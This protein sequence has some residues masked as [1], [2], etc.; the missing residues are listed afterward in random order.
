MKQQ[1]AIVHTDAVQAAGKI[2]VDFQAL[3]VDLMS[4][5]SHKMYGPKGCGALIASTDIKSPLLTGGGQESG[6]H[7]VQYMTSRPVTRSTG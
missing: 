4:L 3:G 1:G 2:P 7:G 6:S 5:S